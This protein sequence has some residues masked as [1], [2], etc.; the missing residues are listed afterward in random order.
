MEM[1]RLARKQSTAQLNP[2]Q[3]KKQ[4]QM[5]VSTNAE[6]DELVA[7]WKEGDCGK[8]SKNIPTPNKE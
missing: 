4:K 1:S 8:F 6:E 7:K 2:L 3:G 5:A